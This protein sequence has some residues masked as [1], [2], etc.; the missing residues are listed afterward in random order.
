MGT[1]FDL[2]ALG[3][4]GWG[5]VLFGAI[6]VLVLGGVIVYYPAAG[7]VSIIAFSGSAFIVGGF[8][9]IYLAFL[10]KAVKGEVNEAKKAVGSV[11][12]SF[13]KAV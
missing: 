4:R 1:A 6:L 12:G 13:K 11:T 2:Q 3:V 9:N 5:W 10:L 7:V 8:M